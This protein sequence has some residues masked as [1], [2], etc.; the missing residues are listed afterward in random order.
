M[1]DAGKEMA[2]NDI[3]IPPLDI[4]WLV[5]ILISPGA[6]ASLT[7]VAKAGVKQ[8]T[9]RVLAKTPPSSIICPH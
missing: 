4:A 1:M 2:P 7:G 9:N 6:L 3:V 8:A 5:P